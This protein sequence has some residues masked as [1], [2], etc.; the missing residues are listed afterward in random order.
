MREINRFGPKKR[1]L[2]LRAAF[3]AI[4]LALTVGALA[5]RGLPKGPGGWE[6]IGISIIFF[7]ATLIWCIRKLLKKDYP[8]E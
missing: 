1:D 2:Q 8:A 7:G 6:A 3:G 5:Y 4:G